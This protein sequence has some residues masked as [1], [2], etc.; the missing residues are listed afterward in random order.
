MYNTKILLPLAVL[1][2]V[3][4]AQTTT[5]DSAQCQSKVNAL[6]AAAPTPS[7]ELSSYFD[8]A[9]ATLSAAGGLLDAP[10]VYVTGLCALATALPS[11]LQ[12]EFRDYGSSLLSF[13]S[14]E[15]SSYDAIVTECVTTG[16]VASSITSYLHSIASEAGHLC[17]EQTITTTVYNNVT[18]GA[19][20]PYPTATSGGASGSGSGVRSTASS[21]TL[22]PTGA[23]ARPSGVFAGAAA[24][25]GILGAVA[26]L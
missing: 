8:S 7:P 3:S 18:S 2:G 20:T 24:V 22:V 15:I 17:Q 25:G 12:S 23:A 4:S 1:A 19:S 9:A 5:T 16:P 26:L 11:S 13:A 10:D 21:S 14:A 6:L